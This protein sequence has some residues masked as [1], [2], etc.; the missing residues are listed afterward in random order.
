VRP[1][2]VAFFCLRLAETPLG[3]RPLR[4]SVDR[5]TKQGVESLN[6][7]SAQVQSGVFQHFGMADLLGPRAVQ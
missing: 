6:A 1:E 7:A 2:Q 5:F 3:A 4:T